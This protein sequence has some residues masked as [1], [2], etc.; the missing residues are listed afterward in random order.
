MNPSIFYA[1][2]VAYLSDILNGNDKLSAKTIDEVLLSKENI[3]QIQ[4]T[5]NL[6]G[7]DT[8][9]PDGIAGSK[10]RKATRMFQSDIG[11]VTD[12]YVGYE[13][14]QLLVKL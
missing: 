8:G 12:A 9:T 6:L 1:L 3:I 13:L 14:F 2:S 10:T 7:Y 11:L 4:D 5:L